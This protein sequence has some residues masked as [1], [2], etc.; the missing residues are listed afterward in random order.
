MNRKKYY[1]IFTVIA[2]VLIVSIILFY[3]SS[4]I[5]LKKS[6][7]SITVRYINGEKEQMI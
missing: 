6:D 5:E 3:G 7:K 4:D 1:I 2:L